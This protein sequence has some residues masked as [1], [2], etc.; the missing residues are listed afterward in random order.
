MRLP[1]ARWCLM[2]RHVLRLCLLR[3]APAA[4]AVNSLEHIPED[5]VARIGNVSIARFRDGDAAQRAA[6]AAALRAAL[7]TQAMVI[8]EDHGV[9]QPAIDDAMTE[10][11]KFFA[12]PRAE[13]DRRKLPSGYPPRSDARVTSPRGWGA[14]SVEDPTN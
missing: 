11:R 14:D 10:A 7:E 6:Q 2:Q 4:A 12:L 9:P 3:A 8:L 1:V 5:G 13:K